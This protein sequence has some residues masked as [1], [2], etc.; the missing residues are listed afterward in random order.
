MEIAKQLYREDDY[1]MFELQISLA[2]NYEKCGEK[3]QA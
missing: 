1:T 2:E 3:E